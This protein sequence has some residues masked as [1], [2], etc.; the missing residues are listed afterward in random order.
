V[1]EPTT[2]PGKVAQFFA[3][4]GLPAHGL[5]V[6]VSGGPDSVALLRALLM[7]AE[8]RTGPRVVVAHFN[9]RLRGAESDADEAFVR[10]LHGSLA[11]GAAE[12]L[13]LC[14]GGGDVGRE[15]AAGSENLENTARRMRYQWLTGVAREHGMRVVLTGHTADDQAETV[16]HRLLRGS[17]LRGLRGI[18]ARRPL[19][20]GVEVA[21]PLLKVT[22]AEVLGFLQ[23][24]GQP[25]RTDLSNEDRRFLRNRIRHELL[26]HLAAE[27]NPAVRS[28]LCRLAAQAEE[29]FRDEEATATRRLAEAERPRAGPIIVLDRQRLLSAPRHELRALFRLL[30][31]REG[32]PQGGMGY[33]EWDRLASVALGEQTAADLPGRIRAC[34]TARVVRLE[35]IP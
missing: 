11:V 31:E 34:S 22:R 23:G 7:P 25:Y 8:E 16:L 18:P 10:D 6:A 1:A 14:V 4:E 20:G 26:P 5:I 33:V 9:H 21:R 24:V 28:L 15:A 17:G 32:W 30:W 2:L 13:T 29:G 27:Y 19:A 12:G 35:A 3:R